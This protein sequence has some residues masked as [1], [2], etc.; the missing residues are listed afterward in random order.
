M[1][2]KPQQRG[3]LY[4][5]KK[6]N[7]EKS[8]KKK[9]PII[10]RWEVPRRQRRRH[11]KKGERERASVQE[12]AAH[13]ITYAKKTTERTA[14]WIATGSKIH[15]N[16]MQAT[17]TACS[18]WICN[19]AGVHEYGCSRRR[20]ASEETREMKSRQQRNVL[21]SRSP[22]LRSL[23]DVATSCKSLTWNGTYLTR[24]SFCWLALRWFFTCG[25]TFSIPLLS[26]LFFSF[27]WVQTR[28]IK[29]PQ[30]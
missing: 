26:F 7:G 19:D 15:E 12:N 10:K 3:H 20:Q 17:I 16:T 6:T 2:L 27:A 13:S 18:V 8:G 9:T 22:K 11:P 29:T 30:Q 25:V 21:Q 1:H 4:K 23:N 28:K 24:V 14:S 5:Q